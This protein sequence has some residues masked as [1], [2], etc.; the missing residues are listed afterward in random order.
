[1]EN[2]NKNNSLKDTNQ[3]LDL[4][5]QDV[6]PIVFF[7]EELSKYGSIYL[8][9]LGFSSKTIKYLESYAVEMDF[10]IHLSKIGTLVIAPNFLGGID[11]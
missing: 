6:D 2:K 4:Y 8:E 1:M 11:K 9:D 10:I 3:N 7:K 5:F